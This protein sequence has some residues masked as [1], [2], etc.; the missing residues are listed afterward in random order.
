MKIDKKPV[1]VR[2]DIETGEKIGYIYETD[3]IIHEEQ[4][5]AIKQAYK[6]KEELTQLEQ[7]NQSLGGFIFAIYEYSKE[8]NKHEEILIQSDLTR[9]VLLATYINYEGY[10]TYDNGNNITKKNMNNILSLSRSK[11][12]KFY[13]KMTS[14]NIIKEVGGKV[15]IDKEYFYKGDIKKIKNVLKEDKT[16]TRIYINTFRELYN[17]CTTRQHKVLGLVYRII[18]YINYEWNI[19]CHNPKE[20]DWK[21]SNMMNLGE[22]ADILGYNNATELKRGLMKFKVREQK[23][24][25]FFN[26]QKD[27]RTDQIVISPYV[28]YQGNNFERL[29]YLRGLFEKNSK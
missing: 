15:Q 3:T 25:G 8:I 28:I 12:I 22:L 17:S 21:K 10:L 2:F 18:P 27:T 13:N 23:V 20:G 6:R 26:T 1:E 24:F 16:Y 4:R 19:I 5:Q 14:L 9:L 29:E 11:F 7:Y